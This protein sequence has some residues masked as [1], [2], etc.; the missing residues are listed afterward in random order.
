M[1]LTEDGTTPLGD[2]GIEIEPTLD[3]QIAGELGYLSQPTPTAPPEAN[4]AQWDGFVESMDME[5]LGQ[6]IDEVPH[7]SEPQPPTSP[8]TTSQRA[9]VSMSHSGFGP[10]RGQ[11]A[12]WAQTKAGHDPAIARIQQDGEQAQLNAIG[13]YD[14]LAAEQEAQGEIEAWHFRETSKLLQDKQDFLRQFNELETIRH[15]EAQAQAQEHLDGAMRQFAAVRQMTVQSPMSQLSGMEFAGITLAAAAQGFLAAQGIN[16]DVTGQLNRWEEI[17]I[18]E[19]ERRIN[20]AEK[21]AQDQMNLWQ[22]AKESARDEQ[23]ARLRHR[24]M[25]LEQLSVGVEM[26]ALRFNSALA[27]SNASIAN[28]KLNIER[29]NIL[30]QIRQNTEAQILAHSKAAADEAYRR[31]MTQLETRKVGIDAMRAQT[32]RDRL[33]KE[34]APPT[35]L[36]I[37]DTRNVQKDAKGNAISGG[38]ILAYIDPSLPD[39]IQGKIFEKVS[40]AQQLHDNL[41]TGLDRLRKLYTQLESDAGPGWWRNRT[42]PAYKRFDAERVR[43]MAD[44]QRFLTGLAAPETE[45]ARILGQ[46][47]DDYI[48]ATGENRLPTLINDMGEWGR[49]RF[50][51]AL[52]IPGVVPIQQEVYSGKLNEP[53]PTTAT[54][55]NVQDNPRIPMRTEH[56]GGAATADTK[57]VEQKPS[58]FYTQT[59][60]E[61]S[62]DPAR[63]FGDTHDR[64]RRG[65]R[66]EAWAAQLDDAARA[67]LKPDEY[68]RNNLRPD[69]VVM[70]LATGA[71]PED[72]LKALQSQGIEILAAIANG[73]SIETNGLPPP[74]DRQEYA[75]KLL[76]LVQKDPDAAWKALNE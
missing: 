73:Q 57:Y 5:V 76:D 70:G 53:D 51:N 42:D 67:Y 36:Y 59:R 40:D 65:D 31:V 45:Q 63:I 38:R 4:P 9:G 6:A 48:F 22:I 68:V 30:N 71:K 16:I 27:Q 1:P 35:P 29:N 7:P 43:T 15:A 49:G 52:K 58:K 47:K 11:G 41:Q 3:E 2:D 72:N 56:L 23:E 17:S 21:G 26:Q 64:I 18:R 25:M 20:Q 55:Y 24:G 44:V 69:E 62:Q 50:T 54:L 75:R 60:A 74:K 8:T 66:V 13:A 32:E 28:A 46:L 10:D 37:Q 19:Q 33:N 39:G 14:N 61:G 12:L 34:K